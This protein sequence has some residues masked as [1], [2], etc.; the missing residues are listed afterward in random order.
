MGLR[1]PKASV[2]VVPQFQSTGSVVA[3]HRLRCSLACGIFPDQGFNL[4]LLHWRQIL[5]HWATREVTHA[6][7]I[8][9]NPLYAI[10][11]SFTTLFI[12]KS[13]HHI[14]TSVLSRDLQVPSQHYNP[15]F[16][17]LAPLLLPSTHLSWPSLL[18]VSTLL[19]WFSLPT[20]IRVQS[21]YQFPLFK[22]WN[23]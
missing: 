4:Y 16:D 11:N 12:F 19:H 22:Q 21:H 17:H 13:Y 8:R 3:A 23:S 2:V 1:A 10:P 18:Y 6:M 14:P 7:F 9:Q 15:L 5:Y 20:E